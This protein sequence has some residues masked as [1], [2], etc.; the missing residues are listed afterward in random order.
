VPVTPGARLGPY[1]VIAKLGAGGMGEV[2]RARDTKLD[3][4]VALKILPESFAS[5][6][7]RLKRFEREA[8]A[9]ASLN[10]PNIAQ[11]YGFEGDGSPAGH[12]ET[13]PLARIPLALVMELVEGQDLSTIIGAAEATPYGPTGISLSDAVSIARQI[14]EA[15]EA[16]HEQ[17]I[18][19][20]DLKPANIKVRADGTVKVLD[21]GLAKALDFRTP[22]P[23]DS[24][25]PGPGTLD[26]GPTMTSPAL[27]AIGIVLGTAAYMSPEQAKG[28]PVDRRA[29]VWAFGCVLYEMLTGR[30]TF[31]GASV[32]ETIASVIKDAP[33]FMALPAETPSGLRRLLRR[34]L[35]KDPEKRLDSMHVVGLD[36]AE[37]MAGAAPDAVPTTPRS[38]RKTAAVVALVA[39]GAV[40]VTWVVKPP[41][42][43]SAVVTRFEVVPPSGPVSAVAISP[44]GMLV[45]WIAPERDGL[46]LRIFIRRTDE[47]SARVLEI[48]NDL[49]ETT[50]ALAFSPDSQ[51]LAF[52]IRRDPTMSPSTEIRRVP[53]TGGQSTLVTK[54]PD[55]VFG[56][57]WSDGTIYFNNGGSIQ[58]V[59]E[60]GGALRTIV[61]ESDESVLQ[62]RPMVINNGRDLLFSRTAI[63]AT[64]WSLHT[65][66]VTG[67]TSRLVM[68]GVFRYA[69]AP[70]GHL[71]YTAADDSV[72][73]ARRF[74]EDRVEVVGDAVP[75]GDLAGTNSAF[76]MSRTGTLV[77]RRAASL[78]T[79]TLWVDR[80][81]GRVDA[82]PGLT[83]QTGSVS[84]STSGR[85]V[86][87]SDRADTVGTM[88]SDAW[89]WDR[90]DGSRSRL[91]FDADVRVVDW[92]ADDTAVLVTQVQTN[93]TLVR[94]RPPWS[95]PPVPIGSGASGL[96]VAIS[97]DGRRLLKNAADGPVLASIDGSGTP[98][99]VEPR[100][101]GQHAGFSP[102]GRWVVYATQETGQPE[103]WMRP[104]P[105]VAAGRW[106]L[107]PVGAQPVFWSSS[108]REVFFYSGERWVSRTVR[109]GAPGAAPV[110]GPA[111][112]LDVPAGIQLRGVTPDGARWLAV[113]P[114][115]EGP[116]VISVVLNFFEELRA[117][118]R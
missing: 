95:S 37:A 66:P 108:G 71:I 69:V 10:H 76:V 75:I 102:D 24:A 28:R 45:A 100:A 2:Y 61:A 68:D 99:P 109:A 14:A 105:E 57:V 51:E 94:A 50:V 104:Y 89:V 9:L 112:P 54:V 15:L 80:S 63:P 22:G 78:R 79:E 65:V 82:I 56:L 110:L 41:P 12:G 29:D 47:F 83:T 58:A 34:C 81:T 101:T 98:T 67:G 115:A 117:K 92:I 43:T 48:G 113:R 90:Q 7:D 103:L 60:S 62:V 107:G 118:V 25:N 42:E 20:R 46:P 38:H 88:G 19:H 31:G 106:R 33:D 84:L 13:R 32:T 53:V 40:A 59:S 97:P 86:L 91:T 64:S 39:A 49:N 55:S 4:D 87:Y 85:Y 26:P 73:F 111:V 70:T 16:A 116:P 35:E 44:D 96:A 36:L 11:I 27:T 6:P 21:F 5:D 74:V 18:V 1:E 17:G 52:P 3:R 30:R 8:K 23:R 93:P 72:L 77:S 114:I